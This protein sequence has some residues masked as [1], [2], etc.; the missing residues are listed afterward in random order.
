VTE[1]DV[2]TALPDPATDPAGF[3]L[4]V[5]DLRELTAGAE[6]TA[7]ANP[8]H[9]LAEVALWRLVAEEHHAKP[10]RVTDGLP[11]EDPVYRVVDTCS[12]GRGSWPCYGPLLP[13]CVAAARAYVG[14]PA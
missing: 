3:I 9:A 4:A 5:A 12:C 1:P 10:T 2:R 11:R 13:A 8:E 14:S 7:E 6:H